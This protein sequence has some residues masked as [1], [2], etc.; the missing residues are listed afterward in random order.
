MEVAAVLHEEHT[1]RMNT[2]CVKK[3]AEVCNITA[4]GAH[5]NY[6]SLKV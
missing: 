6:R 1:K 5:G 4:G 2:E 3:K